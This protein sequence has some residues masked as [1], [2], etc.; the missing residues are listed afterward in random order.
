ML[1]IHVPVPFVIL[2]RIYG[3]IGFELYTY[4]FLVSA[5]FLGQYSGKKLFVRFKNK[6]IIDPTSC[7]IMDF[8]KLIKQ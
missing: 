6:N 8:Y 4:F 3:G 7:L 1:A 5:F 2:L